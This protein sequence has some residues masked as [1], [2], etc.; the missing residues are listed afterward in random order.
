VFIT[1]WPHSRK[2]IPEFSRLFQSHNYT[3]TEATATK[4][5]SAIWQHLGR[6]LAIFSLHV[7]RNRYFSRHLLGTVA[8]P[9][10]HNDP[11]YPVNSCF[12][13]IV[14]CTKIILFD[15]IFPWDC[16]KFPENSMTFPGSENSLSIPG[17]WSPCQKLQRTYVITTDSWNVFH[18]AWE[19]IN[20][21]VRRRPSAAVVDNDCF[22]VL[23][24]SAV[25]CLH[26][27]WYNTQRTAASP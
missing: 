3:F 10:D 1:G 27:Q 16:T 21:P 5:N 20:R 13:Q 8:T 22:P 25:F 6:F 18:S 15:I 11:V 24:S 17:L 9:S 7:R 23:P 4:K 14:N 26:S 12:M 19:V 2:R